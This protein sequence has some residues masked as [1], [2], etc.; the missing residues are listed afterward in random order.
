M[1]D[2][3][4]LR[5]RSTSSTTYAV[6]VFSEARVLCYIDKGLCFIDFKTSNEVIRMTR[7]QFFFK[8][9]HECLLFLVACG[10]KSRITLLVLAAILLCSS[11]ILEAQSLPPQQKIDQKGTYL[12][13]DRNRDSANQATS[14]WLSRIGVSEGDFVGLAVRGDF[15]PRDGNGDVNFA[16]AGVF[17]AGGGQTPIFLPQGP[18][19]TAPPSITPFDIDQDF[20]IT[21]EIVYAQVPVGARKIL[22]SAPDEVFHD[23]E[24]YDDDFRVLIYTLRDV[25][26]NG[27][28]NVLTDK[29]TISWEFRPKYGLTLRE[30]A[31]LG[32]GDHLNW[33]SI[34]R[35]HQIPAIYG[36]DAGKLV[37]ATVQSCQKFAF[38]DCSELLTASGG[39]PSPP[40]FDPPRG[41][42]KYSPGSDRHPWYFDE[43]NGPLPISK[44]GPANG[45]ILK[46]IDRP[47]SAPGGEIDFAT[48]LAIVNKNGTGSSIFLP[49]TTKLWSYKNNT[50]AKDKRFRYFFVESDPPF[51]SGASE[52]GGYM[53]ADKASQ[54]YMFPSIPAQT[55]KAANGRDW[56]IEGLPDF[57]VCQSRLVGNNYTTQSRVFHLAKAT[58]QKS[59]LGF[60]T[61]KHFDNGGKSPWS[62]VFAD[63]PPIILRIVEI[64]TT[65]ELV[66]CFEFDSMEDLIF[67]K[68]AGSF[69]KE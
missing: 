31:M 26:S 57:L 54:L 20:G 41:G 45:K 63:N 58:F 29:T 43:G 65:H 40:F 4:D 60:A 21:K 66:D 38:A 18:E 50:K 34:I 47:N 8:R 48:T 28:S 7:H 42:W 25:T 53:N 64:P 69:S 17:A 67:H 11:T 37:D 61:Y 68:K 5:R 27:Y 10:K 3:G 30:T 9:Y 46:F 59:K 44:Y 55:P 56:L 35:R 15:D 24:D 14:I 51:H 6:D 32:G 23:N 16:L 52:D 19:G 62:L 13:I 22:L 12:P 39:E 49:K 33:Y 2:L 1:K 36:E